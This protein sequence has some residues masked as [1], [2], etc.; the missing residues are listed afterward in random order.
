VDSG[1]VGIVLT[2]YGSSGENPF[3]GFHKVFAFLKCLFRLY[4]TRYLYIPISNST[5]AVFAT[6]LVFTFVALWHDLSLHLLAW[7]WLITLF[8]LPEMLASKA[9]PE[10]KVSPC[11]WQDN[12]S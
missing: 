9:V 5:N 10:K 6:L 8:V 2:T 3:I 11:T 4:H 7:G 12:E 1:E